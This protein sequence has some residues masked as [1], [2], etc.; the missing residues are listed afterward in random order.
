DEARDEL[1]MSAAV[2]LEQDE[3]REVRI[4]VGKGFA[5]RIAAERRPIVLDHVDPGDL[6]NPL[7]REQRIESLLGVPLV[8]AHGVRGVLHVATLEPRSF[9]QDDIDLLEVVADLVSLAIEHARLYEAER[10]ART[11]LERLQTV[12]DVALAHIE[13]DELFPQLLRPIREV[14]DVDTAVVLIL[15]EEANELV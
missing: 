4:P 7:L 8:F 5:G 15:D 13:F 6:L 9:D 3:E 2:G 11:R 12:T 14:L 1:V 10:A